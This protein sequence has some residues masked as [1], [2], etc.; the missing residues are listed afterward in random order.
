[1][2][3]DSTGR[4]ELRV[5]GSSLADFDDLCRRGE[6]ARPRVDMAVL[7]AAITGPAARPA[8][9]IRASRILRG[10]RVLVE[11]ERLAPGHIADRRR[12]AGGWE[13]PLSLARGMPGREA[14]ERIAVGC[15]VDV[16]ILEDEARLAEAVELIARNCGG[17]VLGL[18]MTPA[19]RLDDNTIRKIARKGPE[20]QRHA[21]AEAARGRDP[22][23]RPPMGDWPMDTRSYAKVPG[24]LGRALGQVE[25]CIRDAPQVLPREHPTEQQ[26]TE[27]AGHLAGIV[28]HSNDLLR[29]LLAPGTDA[30]TRGDSGGGFRGSATKSRVVR[31]P[32]KATIAQLVGRL[33]G[34][35]YFVQKTARDVARFPPDS[36][37][38][39]LQAAKILVQLQRL[40]G[41]A[42]AL[43]RSL[44]I[45]GLD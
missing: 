3:A 21:M 40:D 29:Y 39:A 2:A 45:V 36:R 31:E 14:V 24:R 43:A 10:L 6:S 20:R 7:Q 30:A 38:T 16:V 41:R 42:R 17:E 9:T 4:E 23:A 5:L 25:A 13:S 22:M 1:M 37:P 28:E 15:G 26:L 19:G 18:L 33:D 8:P 34:A 11:V 12:E 32:A 27:A 35:R 44:G